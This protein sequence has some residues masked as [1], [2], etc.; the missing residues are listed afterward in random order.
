M[1]KSYYVVWKLIFCRSRSSS[2]FCLNR[3]MQYG[4][5]QKS[6][7]Y[8]QRYCKFKSYYV[9]WKPLKFIENKKKEANAFKSYYVVWKLQYLSS[10][11]STNFSLNRTM[12]YGNHTREFS[13]SYFLTITFKSY[14][15][16]WKLFSIVVFYFMFTSLNRTMQYGNG[17][18]SS[19]YRRLCCV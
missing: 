2:F 11:F 13:C 9:V 4:N 15:V 6:S 7:R 5:M 19:R 10:S 1:F 8:H 17:Q 3:T 16:V 18:K 12:Q 14:Y